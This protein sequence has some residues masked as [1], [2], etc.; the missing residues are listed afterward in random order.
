M[1]NAIQIYEFSR[2]FENITYSDKYARFVSGGYGHE[3]DRA[4]PG[5]D[6][7]EEIRQA[8]YDGRF[9]INDNYPPD[10]IA[11]IA[12]EISDYGVLAIASKIFDDKTRPLIAYRYFWAQKYQ[13]DSTDIVGSLLYWWISQ[14]GEEL[15]TPLQYFFPDED[16]TVATTQ[17]KRIDKNFSSQ[18][19]KKSL[20]NQIDQLREIPY[21]LD[22]SESI[23]LSELHSVS[24][25]VR[26]TY[27]PSNLA[28]AWN[29]RWLEHPEAFQFI[30]CADQQAFTYNSGSKK[31]HL[32][33]HQPVKT[34]HVERHASAS[35]VTN[36]QKELYVGAGASQVA[37]LKKALREIALSGIKNNNNKFNK[38]ITILLEGLASCPNINW[39]DII[40]NTT[41]NQEDTDMAARYKALIVLLNKDIKMTLDW[42]KWLSK[43]TSS[44]R[45]SL[46]KKSDSIYYDKYGKKTIEFQSNL[47][48]IIKSPF[49]ETHTQLCLNIKKAIPNI[50]YEYISSSY[51]SDRDK[52][53]KKVV[54][55]LLLHPE[56]IWLDCFKDYLNDF[57]SRLMNENTLP[58]QACYDD[59]FYAHIQKNWSFLQ[60][61]K[62][63]PEYQWLGLNI[64]R[65]AELFDKAGNGEAS[66]SLYRLIKAKIPKHLEK[67][68][69]V[70]MH[71]SSLTSVNEPLVRAHERSFQR[72]RNPFNSLNA[73]QVNI[74]VGLIFLYSVVFCFIA[75][76]ILGSPFQAWN[77]DFN[78][79]LPKLPVFNT[80][81][82]SQ[83][84]G[85]E[86]NTSS[87]CAIAEVVLDCHLRRYR[88]NQDDISK[89]WIVA[90]LSSLSTRVN[91]EEPAYLQSS[92][93]L[94]NQFGALDDIYQ[95][96]TRTQRLKESPLKRG[97]SDASS[98]ES[99]KDIFFVQAT[100]YMML[101]YQ[102]D[103]IKVVTPHLGSDKLPILEQLKNSDRFDSHT[104]KLVQLYQEYKMQ[105]YEQ[106][107]NP[108]RKIFN[109][110]GQVGPATL[111]ELESSFRY[112][113]DNSFKEEQITTISTFLVDRLERGDLRL[114]K[115]LENP[116]LKS[117]RNRKIIEFLECVDYP[118]KKNLNRQPGS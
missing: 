108:D 52:S 23:S 118:D 17:A 58:G 114:S 6:V 110:D 65:I 97:D 74:I 57:Q 70:A 104:E 14:S 46:F 25:Q 19:S 28:W 20:L 11:V 55:S 40:E 22:N 36:E 93:Y 89:K 95:D 105:Q 35:L 60:K 53:Y 75:V 5:V 85:M 81:N 54:K 51:A 1:T 43:S 16:N 73:F 41:F 84:E 94:L 66:L 24:L 30:H 92:S 4:T 80:N 38:D 27:K 67:E 106:K 61:I 107:E 3:I 37:S 13:V 68:S 8:V 102:D 62:D 18:F 91:Q 9:R 98:P 99:Q 21:I 117:C 50:L 87:P 90:H 31:Q 112:L 111:E 103:F 32:A 44:N 76:D 82:S 15:N 64:M 39:E 115:Q 7:P 47:G 34:H 45:I 78:V 33:L 83:G 113:V 2:G 116:H 77:F 109:A 69:N 49:P 63:Y 56:S 88:E 59:K 29:V 42:T 12:R 72:F 48:L 26:Q 86:G 79:A 100:L 96:D 71:R 101:Q 10:D